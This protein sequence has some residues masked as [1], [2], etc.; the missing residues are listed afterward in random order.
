MNAGAAAGAAYAGYRA[1]GGEIS[2]LPAGT[3][4][5]ALSDVDGTLDCARVD[6]GDVRELANDVT[7]SGEEEPAAPVSEVSGRWGDDGFELSAPRFA[8][9]RATLIDDRF[10]EAVFDATHGRC[11]PGVA[12]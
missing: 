4:T 10:G 7:L 8:E 3:T 1:I 5:H 2:L 6:V 12:P 11:G 9:P